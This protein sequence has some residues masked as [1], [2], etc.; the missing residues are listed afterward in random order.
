V[1]LKRLEVDPPTP[2]EDVLSV[3]ARLSGQQRRPRPLEVGGREVPEPRVVRP[4]REH[5]AGGSHPLLGRPDRHVHH[6]HRRSDGG[7]DDPENVIA[8]CPNCH[9]RVHHGRDS[10]EFNQEL[11]RKAEERNATFS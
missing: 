6:L 8:L 5:I 7:A 1:F 4:F 10:E 3:D 2:L 11:I 9:R